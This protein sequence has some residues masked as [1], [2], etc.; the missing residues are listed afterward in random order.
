MAVYAG[1]DIV[2]NGLV[3]S[4][5]SSNNK[6]FSGEIFYNLIDSQT[7]GNPSW[8]NGAN[9]LTILSVIK[10]LGNDQ[11][12]A[13]HA[14]SKWG[15]SLENTSFVLYHFQNYQGNAPEW[16]N[17]LL[18]YAGANNV[19]G[20]ITNGFKATPNTTY[21]VV[22]QYNS[23]TGGQLWINNSKIGSRGIS[24]TLGS[25]N[26][27]IVIDGNVSGRSGIHKVEMVKMYNRELQDSEILQMYEVFKHKL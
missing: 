1:P 19:W 6:S 5:D 15:T 10:I 7:L 9:Q 27:S 20:S 22:L 13:Y 16:S 23:S 14:I 4:I 24:G 17:V 21:F 12:Y 11:N 18:W 3:L 25:A 26:N 2:E 8:A